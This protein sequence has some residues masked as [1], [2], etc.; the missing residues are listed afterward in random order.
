MKEPTNQTEFEVQAWLWNEL[1]DLGYNIRGEVKVKKNF[2]GRKKFQYCR[3]DLAEFVGGELA[4]II[5]VKATPVKHKTAAGWIGT[6]QGTRYH[7]FGVPVRIVYGMA[8]AMDLAQKAA[9]NR[10]WA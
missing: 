5:E 7:S 9:D 3:F 1:K 2:N 10:L 8:G 4:G 6:R